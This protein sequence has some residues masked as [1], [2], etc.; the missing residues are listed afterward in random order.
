MIK[1]KINKERTKQKKAEAL[2]RQFQSVF[3]VE[4][5]KELP[6]KGSSPFSNMP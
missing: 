1:N 5:N 3:A 6:D 2:N 4:S